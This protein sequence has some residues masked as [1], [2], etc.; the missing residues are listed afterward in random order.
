MSFAYKTGEIAEVLNEQEIYSRITGTPVAGTSLVP[1]TIYLAD[2][3]NDSLFVQANLQ[4]PL[5]QYAVSGWDKAD[6]AM[7]L[8]MVAPARTVPR[9]FEYNSYTNKE[10]FFTDTAGDDLRS[11]G[12][13]FKRVEYT[14]AKNTSRTYN[15]GLVIRV[16]LDE[17]ANR[18]NWQEQYTNLLMRR[19]QRNALYR[20]YTLAIATGTNT[21]R[22]WTSG[23]PDADFDIESTLLT[24]TNASGLRPNTVVYGHTAWVYRKQGYRVDSNAAR[25]YNSSIAPQDLATQLQINNIIISKARYQSSASAKTEMLGAKVL[26]FYVGDFGMED[27]SNFQRFVSNTDSG[28]LVSVYYNRVSQK[29]VDLS[30]EYY[31]N[32][33]ATYSTG[34]R[35]ETIS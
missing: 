2:A 18:P 11:E 32:T 28:G 22:T 24:A 29:L 35:K 14:V 7:E 9:R 1:G 6:L 10:S 25:F 12:A 5:T 15:R 20:F 19:A 3:T 21:A 31:E 33:V 4:Q 16:D 13:D 30:L 17:V 23:T 27:P 26:S 8:E 34:V